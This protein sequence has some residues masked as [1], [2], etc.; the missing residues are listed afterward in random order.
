MVPFYLLLSLTL[1]LS[2][3]V[4]GFIAKEDDLP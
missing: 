2:L 1:S 3:I 4:V